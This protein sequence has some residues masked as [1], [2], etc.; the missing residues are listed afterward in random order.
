MVI[1]RAIN[2]G[3]ASRRRLATKKATLSI[4]VF[5]LFASVTTIA[6]ADTFGYN[7][8]GAS[9]LNIKN[10]LRGSK[11]YLSTHGEAY[12]IT[13]NLRSA[14]NLS[15]NFRL[16]IY[17]ENY[18]LEAATYQ[19]NVTL[20]STA[21][22]YTY[23]LVENT[24]LEVGYYWL[25]A[26]GNSSGSEPTFAYNSAPASSSSGTYRGITYDVVGLPYTFP[27]ESI[28]DRWFSI[29][30][31]YT[32]TEE[33][34][35]TSEVISENWITFAGLLTLAM[36]CVILSWKSNVPILNFVFGGITLGAGA[37]YLGTDMVFAGWVN[38]LAIVMS[39][40]CMLSGAI[41]LRG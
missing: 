15:C 6:Y 25:V 36:A 24:T 26:L 40:V 8:A 3:G 20:T 1:Q 13:V 7:T 22:W 38:M 17:N 31:N 2:Y 28:S 41:K 5:L 30:V 23:N 39:I 32:P 10:A 37:Y 33:T 12:S 27:A 29:Y 11:Y 21:T 9:E 18:T 4:I 34:E 19:Q 16:G 35:V 14:S